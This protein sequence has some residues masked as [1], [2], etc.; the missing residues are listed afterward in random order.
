VVAVNLSFATSFF[1]FFSNQTTAQ[2]RLSPWSHDVLSKISLRSHQ[3][4]KSHAV[5]NSRRREEAVARRR[6]R[7]EAVGAGM[8]KYVL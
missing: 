4:R 2:I 6:C 8:F 5:D 3:R 1:L 7:E